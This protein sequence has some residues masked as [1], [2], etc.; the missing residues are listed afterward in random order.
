M[1]IEATRGHYVVK[2]I[3]D[4]FMIQYNYQLLGN[5]GIDE[6]NLTGFLFLILSLSLKFLA[7]S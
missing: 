5:K 1:Y 4:Q 3:M 6:A 7:S 2:H